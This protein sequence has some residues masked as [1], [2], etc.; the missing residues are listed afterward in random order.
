MVGLIRT[1]FWKKKLF[2]TQDLSATP[3]GS[4]QCALTKLES[5]YKKVTPSFPLQPLFKFSERMD[6]SKT[7]LPADSTIDPF[8]LYSRSLHDYTLRLWTETRRIAEERRRAQQL[9]MP[10][11]SPPMEDQTQKKQHNL[12]SSDSSSSQPDQSSDIQT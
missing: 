2:D 1:T 7:S 5:L 3:I 12:S 6:E 10:M 9:E 11:P 8:V 4:R